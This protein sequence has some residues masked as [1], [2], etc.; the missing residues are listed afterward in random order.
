MYENQANSYIPKIKLFIEL[1]ANPEYCNADKENYKQILRKKWREEF[2]ISSG[3]YKNIDNL[4]MNKS[5]KKNWI[6]W[7]N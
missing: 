7:K 5:N 1:G 4:I 6:F 2:L 3:I